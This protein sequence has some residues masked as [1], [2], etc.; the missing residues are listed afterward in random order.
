MATFD[1]WLDRWA[2]EIDG[3][4]IR[5]ASSDLLPVLRDGAPAMLK[6]ARTRE[7][8]R[9][10][11]ILKWYA[12]EGAVRVLEIDGPALLLERIRSN[13]SLADMSKGGHDDAATRILCATVKRLHAERAW[14]VPTNL[15]PLDTWFRSL[16]VSQNQVLARSAAAARELLVDSRDPGVLHGD[17]HHGNVLHDVNRGWL[18]IDPKGLWGER[19]FDYANIFCNPDLETATAPG[20]LARQIAIV[21]S[22]AGL[23]ARRLLKWVLAYAG[24]SAAWCLEER[25][26][27]TLP[28]TVAQIASEQLNAANH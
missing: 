17:I 3:S 1:P 27:A 25:Q 20:R 15:V 13:Q 11:S 28:L 16:M 21:A 18:A 7:E 24:L 5:T 12:G 23:D 9:G 4:P 10:A 14:A 26:D 22:K 8:Q 2:L 19:S 6:I